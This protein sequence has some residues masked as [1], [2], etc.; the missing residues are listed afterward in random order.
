MKFFFTKKI[1]KANP[2]GTKIVSIPRALPFKI[3]DIVKV[4]VEVVEKQEKKNE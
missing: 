2:Y 1:W 3:G 4:S